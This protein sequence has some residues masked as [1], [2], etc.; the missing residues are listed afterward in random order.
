MTGEEG[1]GVWSNIEAI[2]LHVPA[3]TLSVSHAFRLASA[4][5]GDREKANEVADGGFA[6]QQLDIQDKDGFIEDL[7]KATYAACLASYIQGMNIISRADVEH[8]WGINYDNVWQIWRAGCIIQADYISDNILASVLKSRSTSPADIN[9]LF[10]QHVAKDI[11]AS[12]LSLKKVVAKAVA[13]DQVVPALSA[14]LEYFKV[15]TGT[16]LPTSFYEAE[17]DYFGAHMFDKKSEAG[18]KGVK[19]PM[20][21]KH[22]FEWKPV[23]SQ[24]E[25]YGHASKI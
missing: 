15:V 19:K 6:P 25:E 13:T 23:R 16:D 4:F 14:T 5:R 22:H 1:T 2:D 24:S 7:R 11:R 21:G 20:E 17:M 10:H 9:L 3:F 8:E 18:N 12:F